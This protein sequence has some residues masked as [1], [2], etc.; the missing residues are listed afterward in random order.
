MAL[1]TKGLNNIE[2]E[3]ERVLLFLA[4][5]IW[6]Y[7]I[8][9]KFIHKKITFYTW[10]II[11]QISY[12]LCN[13]FYFEFHK[14]LPKIQICIL[15]FLILWEDV[16][17]FIFIALSNKTSPVPYASVPWHKEKS[18]LLMPFNLI[19]ENMAFDAKQIFKNLQNK[20]NELTQK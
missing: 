2:R 16:A 4:D 10:Y 20:T 17:G 14:I 6:K 7:M 11:Q 5:S 13:R 8:R 9:K 15:D 3:K 12:G 18:I 1:L 19:T